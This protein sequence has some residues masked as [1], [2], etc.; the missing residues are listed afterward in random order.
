MV[1]RSKRS[2]QTVV[3]PP[4]VSPEALH[5]QMD[6][7]EVPFDDSEILRDGD[8]IEVHMDQSATE[9]AA[10]KSEHSEAGDD[11]DDGDDAEED[12]DQDEDSDGHEQFARDAEEREAILEASRLAA[13]LRTG[14]HNLFDD[15]GDDLLAQHKALDD[16][17]RMPDSSSSLPPRQAPKPSKSTP[18]KAT[19]VSISHASPALPLPPMPMSFLRSSAA[20]MAAFDAK[21]KQMQA[22]SQ[23][24]ARKAAATALTRK[25][26]VASTK[27]SSSS[28]SEDSSSSDSDS[29]S[30]SDSDS[31]SGSS[32]A[33]SSSTGTDSDADSDSES[34]SSDTS[35]ETSD[36]DHDSS[37]SDSA[38]SE[39]GIQSD[40]NRAAVKQ[41]QTPTLDGTRSAS[42]TPPGQG[43]N[44]T[45]RR[46][47]MRRKKL[48]DLRDAENLLLFEQA[49][50]RAARRE[51]GEDVDDV[52]PVDQAFSWIEDRKPMLQ[53]KG[54]GLAAANALEDLASSLSVRGSFPPGGGS[55]GLDE[56]NDAPSQIASSSSN[57]A[58]KGTKRKW[59]DEPTSGTD[60]AQPQPPAPSMEDMQPGQAPYGGEVPA[61]I[62][63]RHIDCQTYY[64]KEFEKLEAQAAGEEA[65][66]RHGQDEE[67]A[68]NGEQ[69][70][71]SKDKRK[72]KYRHLYH[73]DRPDSQ[74]DVGSLDYGLPEEQL[75][76]EAPRK[77]VKVDQGNAISIASIV[78]EVAPASQHVQLGSPTRREQGPIDPAV[79]WMKILG[80]SKPSTIAG[81][82][83]FAAAE[84]KWPDLRPGMGLLWK[85][86]ALDPMKMI[87]AVMNFVGVVALVH[88]QDGDARVAD[89]VDVD[90]MGPL[91]ENVE[92]DW[93][94]YEVEKLTWTDDTRPAHI[95]LGY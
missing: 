43:T 62:S 82:Q 3:L 1:S 20:T 23:P 16:L 51:R 40:R 46:N 93:A 78:S 95:Y 42:P 71:R 48:R 75:E 7:F 38:P 36:S 73:E 74:D 28:S 65:S 45:K 66:S 61:G 76:E 29:N 58:H 17:P 49:K 8:T 41:Q 25:P 94:D 31:D 26:V 84:V 69:R 19:K 89:S 50:D 67:K 87:P 6:N 63:I 39:H 5:F 79:T 55:F 83:N 70:Q 85:D 37:S 81:K 52:D 2:G 72:G 47:Q 14:A 33:D 54:I 68:D 35:S 24:K 4:S 12:E 80:G 21:R 53:I 90:V 18:S 10:V 59:N 64:D 27:R 88:R 57:E 30:S 34:D 56:A 11:D 32:S 91:E 13:L 9:S 44:R 77:K 22:S 60:N 15:D 92:K 86:L